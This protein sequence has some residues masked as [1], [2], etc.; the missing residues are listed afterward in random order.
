ML[1]E[2]GQCMGGPRHRPISFHWWSIAGRPKGN[3]TTPRRMVR[4]SGSGRA[5]RRGYG[6]YLF[7]RG[8]LPINRNLPTNRLTERRGFADA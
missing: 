4:V 2:K 3:A 8:S 5:R 6:A 7:L 1:I